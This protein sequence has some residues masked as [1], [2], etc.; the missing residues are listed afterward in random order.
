MEFVVPGD[1][2]GK[3]NDYKL[4]D[5]VY[6]QGEMIYAKYAGIKKI[7]N[8]MNEKPTI[9][10]VKSSKIIPER[11]IPIVGAICVCSVVKISRNVCYVKL[12]STN[13]YPLKQDFNGMIKKDSIWNNQ[14]DTF[15]IQ[16]AFQ[17]GDIIIARIISIVESQRNDANYK[18]VIFLATNEKELGV[19]YALSKTNPKQSLIPFSWKE[20]ANHSTGLKEKRKVAKIRFYSSQF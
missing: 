4:G 13:G 9:K 15:T 19:I 17:I 11:S 6:K 1:E 12:L 5:G 18:N 20:M 2:L 10:V 7:Q 16:N 8:N 14:I 3:N